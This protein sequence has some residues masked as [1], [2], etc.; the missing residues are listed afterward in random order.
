MFGVKMPF[1]GGLVFCMYIHDKHDKIDNSRK[2][3]YENLQLW[4]VSKW[5]ASRST[6]S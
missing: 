3:N 1:I 4:G 6:I 2:G 5:E